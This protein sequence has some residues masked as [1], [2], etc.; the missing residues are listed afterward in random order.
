MTTKPWHS[1]I[2]TGIDYSMG[3]PM[4]NGKIPN[5]NEPCVLSRDWRIGGAMK[6][7]LKKCLLVMLGYDFES[8]INKKLEMLLVAAGPR[9]GQYERL[10]KL[11]GVSE[12]LYSWN[13]LVDMVEEK[14]KE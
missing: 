12:S 9:A 13:E 14:L 1:H 2:Y 8:R 5:I 10:C 7:Q 4:A 6:E 11:L 3:L